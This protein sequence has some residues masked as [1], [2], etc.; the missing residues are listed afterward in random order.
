MG[1]IRQT[2]KRGE[3][4]TNFLRINPLNAPYQ[5]LLA[6]VSKVQNAMAQLKPFC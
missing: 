2:V 3:H 4:K 6:F 5:F 1:E